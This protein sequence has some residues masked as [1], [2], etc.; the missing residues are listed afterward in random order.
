M[1][2][3][4]YV[5]LP[6]SPRGLHFHSAPRSSQF[7][8]IHPFNPTMLGSLPG[9]RNPP[10]SGLLAIERLPASL[11][12]IP[13]CNASGGLSR[14]SVGPH[15]LFR[16]LEAGAMLKAKG[17]GAGRAAGYTQRASFIWCPLFSKR[18]PRPL[19]LSPPPPPPLQ[20]LVPFH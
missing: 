19:V 16:W 5:P 10:D 9:K 1:C 4:A 17:R 2:K 7:A 15:T 8:S 3:K 13:Q 20:G 18:D 6:L 14:A 11:P 12:F